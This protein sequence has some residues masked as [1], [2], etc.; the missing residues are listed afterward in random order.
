MV[1]EHTEENKAWHAAADYVDWCTKDEPYSRDRVKEAVTRGDR[2]L[3]EAG[4]VPEAMRLLW[5]ART[6]RLGEPL[7][8]ALSDEVKKATSKDHYDYLHSMVREGV[9]S[10][11]EYERKRVEAEPYPSA[12]EH[13]DELYEKTWKDARYGIVLL[14]SSATSTQAAPRQVHQQGGKTH[15][16]HAGRE[17]GYA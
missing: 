13:I 17:C 14:C 8:G 16:C 4:S 12:L 5:D 11:R 1:E 3:L 2:L 10:R 6:S 15:P 9:P 7:E